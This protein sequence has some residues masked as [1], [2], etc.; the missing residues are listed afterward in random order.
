MHCT[1][2]A[3]GGSC[4]KGVQE[5]DAPRVEGDSEEILQEDVSAPSPDSPEELEALNA[6]YA[7]IEAKFLGVSLSTSKRPPPLS[8]PKKAESGS[9]CMR[10]PPQVAKRGSQEEANLSASS[11]AL[12]E[13]FAS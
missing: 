4:E 8:L 9:V 7:E 6:L 1:P 13:V 2:A 5:E 12:E 11:N 3:A 10:L